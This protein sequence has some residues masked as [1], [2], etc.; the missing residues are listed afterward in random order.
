[1]SRT[2]GSEGGPS[3]AARGDSLVSVAVLARGETA[4]TLAAVRGAAAFL[5]A[6]FEF[7]EILVLVSASEFDRSEAAYTGLLEI[8][9]ARCL[10]LRDGTGEYRAAIVAA[11]ESIGDVA[12]ILQADEARDIDLDLVFDA[13]LAGGGS[14]ILRRVQRAGAVPGVIG[15]LLSRISGYDV[16]PRFLR[17][18]AHSRGHIARIAAR[19]DREIALRF[20]PRGGARQG[21]ITVLDVSVPRRE[22]QRGSLLRRVGNAMEVMANSPPHLL[23]L[24][25]AVSL[26]VAFWAVVYFLYAMVLF[27]LGVDLQ[28]GWFTTTVAISGS[29]AFLGLALGGIST[30]LYQI[31]NLL[32]ED[33]GDEVLRE[34]HNTDLFRDF[35][36]INV[37]TI[38]GE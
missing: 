3:P 9:N 7:Y 11:T 25:S 18:A 27:V 14:V 36:R 33:A 38:G 37:E 10:V 29:T 5:E 21:D 32:R 35:R 24:L 20:V 28:P 26:G 2:T 6:R 17:S 30:A 15:R 12:L 16:D 1:M 19:A 23:R 4:E 31:L 34:I 22:A 8:R 13:A